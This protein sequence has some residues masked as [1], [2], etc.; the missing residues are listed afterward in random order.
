[1]RFEQRNAVC[2]SLPTLTGAQTPLS[3]HIV[4]AF[5]CILSEAG[6]KR[7]SLLGRIFVLGWVCP[8]EKC[9][10]VTS[11]LSSGE[12]DPPAIG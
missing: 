7:C 6:T 3:I 8:M 2:L 5:N 9:S 1:V 10:A 11:T 4:S 12:L